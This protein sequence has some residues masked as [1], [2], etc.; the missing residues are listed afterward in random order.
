MNIRRFRFFA[1]ILAAALLGTSPGALSQ[2][3]AQTSSESPASNGIKTLPPAYEEEML[4][5]AEILG[6]LHYLR[7][8]CKA[9][10]GP[11]WRK[12][13]EELIEKEAPTESRRALLVARFNRGYRGFSEIHRE[14]T[15]T[16]AE[17]A[18]RYRRQGIRLAAEIP[19]RYGN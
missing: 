7:G 18:N 1:W 14:C 8:L 4:R 19:D 11:I 12:Q 13:M 5:L 17:A 2:S 16:A 3:A 9:E 10:E 15:P 6:A